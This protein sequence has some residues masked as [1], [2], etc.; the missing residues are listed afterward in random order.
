MGRRVRRFLGKRVREVMTVWWG[1]VK[2]WMRMV[3]GG[4]IRLLRYR[5]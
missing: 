4:P 5:V 1:G 2:G 3:G